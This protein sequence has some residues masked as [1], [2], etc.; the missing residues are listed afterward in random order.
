MAYKRMFVSVLP[1]K[2]IV[3]YS[4]QNQCD[5]LNFKNR[6]DYDGLMVRGKNYSVS[7]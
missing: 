1:F 3:S 6:L 2:H 5:D 4:N 7:K